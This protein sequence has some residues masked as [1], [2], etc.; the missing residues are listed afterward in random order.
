M[1]SVDLDFG[2]GAGLFDI[3]LRLPPGTILGLI[4]P[5]GCGK[6]TLVRILT[7]LYRPAAGR[8]FVFGKPPSEFT[9]PDKMRIGYIPQQMIL[10][11]H[12]SAAENLNVI[13][14]MYGLSPH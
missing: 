9:E 7:G 1:E 6:T 12:L 4:G 3:S 10:Y 13:G 5:S 14:G 11:D 8:A 2:N